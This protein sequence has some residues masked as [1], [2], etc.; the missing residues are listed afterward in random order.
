MAVDTVCKE[1]VTHL[2]DKCGVRS[3][4]KA[5]LPLVV[6]EWYNGV[7]EVPP[8]APVREL[9]LGDGTTAARAE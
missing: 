8:T 1:L 2:V 6:F 3:G 4:V 5:L 9:H 7:S